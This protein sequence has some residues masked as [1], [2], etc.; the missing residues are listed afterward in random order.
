MLVAFNTS[1]PRTTRDEAP[2][3]RANASEPLPPGSP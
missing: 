1:P 2:E 3:N